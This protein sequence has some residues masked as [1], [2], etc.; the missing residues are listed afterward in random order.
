MY[1]PPE[2]ALVLAA[3][4]ADGA[5]ELLAADPELAIQRFQRQAGG[6]PVRCEVA[7]PLARQKLR[8]GPEGAHAVELLAQPVAGRIHVVR[9]GFGEQEWRCLHDR[10]WLSW[11]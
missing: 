6:E 3:D 4:D 5:L 7:M 1:F 2:R 8:A 10:G 11:R 9:P